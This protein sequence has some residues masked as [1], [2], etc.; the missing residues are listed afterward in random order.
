MTDLLALAAELV[1][2]PSVT[3]DEDRLASQ[4][5]IELGQ[6]PWLTVD[7]LGDTVVAR[8][9]LGRDRRVVLAG[10]TDTV[11][12]PAGARIEGDTLYGTG[13]ADMKAGLAV[14][15]ELARSI[16]EPVVDV[17]YVFYAR[18]EGSF[19]DN[20]LGVVFA[21]RPDLLAGDLALLGEPTDAWIEA[22]CQGSLRIEVTLQGA[23]AHTAR[24]WMGDNAIHR[25]GRLLT[26]VEGFE[27]RRPVIDGCEFREALQ[28]VSVGG[29][30]AGNVVPDQATV[31]LNHR[32]A[33]DRTLDEAV[34]GVRALL[35]P[36]LRDG[37][38]FDVL[39]R[40]EP[41]QPGLG[42]PL[43][44]DLVRR[45]GLS[46]RA[47]LGWT[48]VARFSAA[49]VPAS[50]FGPGDPELAHTAGERVNRSAIDAVHTALTNLLTTPPEE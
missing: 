34:A 36:V 16:S 2:I 24:P 9:N 45:A 49:G 19:A 15:L 33:P 10:H 30:V 48:D 26:L 29:G 28:A 4:I 46:V 27:E 38:T 35:A 31:T 21:E 23:R 39:D 1:A 6:V 13:A 20:E 40:S 11:P 14:Y 18:E 32:V 44:A 37:D 3:G 50:N 7:R 43:L 22:G 47:K 12:G 25:M 41:A 42:D 5:E 8:T 17:S